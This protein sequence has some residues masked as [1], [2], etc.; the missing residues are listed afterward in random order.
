[1]SNVLNA[2]SYDEKVEAKKELA[3]KM[4]DDINKRQERLDKLNAEIEQ[5]VNEK[6]K[7]VGGYVVDKMLGL[8]DEQKKLFL[9][10]FDTIVNKFK[11]ENATS[12][13]TVETDTSYENKETPYTSYDETETFEDEQT[14]EVE[15]TADTI[16]EETVTEEDF[17]ED[18]TTSYSNSFYQQNRNFK[19]Y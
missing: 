18:S 8:T 4:Q 2:V 6:K 14:E 7:T 5:M 3:A 17:E 11:E 12:T 10:N 16:K 19:R 1:M 13:A 15:E 9:E